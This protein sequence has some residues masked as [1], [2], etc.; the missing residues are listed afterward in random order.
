MSFSF[1]GFIG[2]VLILFGGIS[3]F[4]QVQAVYDGTV[5]QQM[6]INHNAVITSHNITRQWLSTI[7]QQ[8]Q[9]NA[10]AMVDCHRETY[11]KL[12]ALDEKLGDPTKLNTNIVGVAPGQEYGNK[13]LNQIREEGINGAINTNCDAETLYG[14][15]AEK[16]RAE[17]VVE[18]AYVNYES[19][20]SKVTEDKATLIRK[21]EAII[22]A[23]PQLTNLAQITK[24]QVALSAVDSKLKT[25]AET[26]KN[27]ALKV[28]VTQARNEEQRKLKETLDQ[29]IGAQMTVGATEA[30]TDQM[31]ANFEAA[32]KELKKG[33]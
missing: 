28:L 1:S 24:L 18:A 7:L 17:K 2:T 12:K 20:M 25:I 29:S 22:A 33:K 21:R 6:V 11:E 16:G 31:G 26:E 30:M 32:I 15:D 19:V 3:L 10:N 13:A 14:K 27:A 4:A 8:I 23:L 5:H 9:I